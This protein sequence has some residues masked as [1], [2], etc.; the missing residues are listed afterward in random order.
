MM[1]TAAGVTAC[2]VLSYLIR[3]D[4]H[5]AAYVPGA[6]VLWAIDAIRGDVPVHDYGPAPRNPTVEEALR[7]K[8]GQ[9]RR[10]KRPR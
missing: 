5:L 10:P 6:F 1:G 2:C 7:A 9:K 3:D 4:P 8:R